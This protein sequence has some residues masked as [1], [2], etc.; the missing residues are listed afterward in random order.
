MSL[1]PDR[2]MK[3]AQATLSCRLETFQSCAQSSFY[4]LK[5]YDQTD[6]LNVSNQ[7]LCLLE[8]FFFSM[9]SWALRAKVEYTGN[10][11]KKLQHAILEQYSQ[12]AVKGWVRYIL[13]LKETVTI[14]YT[15]YSFAISCWKFFLANLRFWFSL[16]HVYLQVL[17]LMR[18][19][20][21]S[22]ALFIKTKCIATICHFQF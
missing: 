13:K 19:F 22:F 3:S 6:M 5:G 17:D 2:K 20:Y 11:K 21:Y 18:V 16:L 7:S 10:A 9:L 8:W 15:S 1:Q 12:A 4:G 14:N